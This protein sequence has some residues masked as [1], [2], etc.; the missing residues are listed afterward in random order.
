MQLEHVGF[1]LGKDATLPEVNLRDGRL[2]V[3]VIDQSPS[4]RTI[5]AFF[6]GGAHGYIRKILLECW[7]Q[8]DEEIVVHG[9]FQKA[10][11]M[12]SS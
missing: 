9:I 4:S 8:K 1:N 2:S 7:K 11:N 3:L 5:L 6:A 10:S 12:M